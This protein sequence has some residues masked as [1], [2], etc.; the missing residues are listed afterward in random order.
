MHPRLAEKIR[1]MFL[2]G[3]YT[4]AVQQS[5]I[6]VEI[7]VREAAGMANDDLGVEMMRTVFSNKTGKLADPNATG[8]ERVAMMELFAG[9]IGHCKNPPSHRHVDTARVAAAQL[10]GLA[11]H[12]LSLVEAA[13]ARLKKSSP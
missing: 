13:E 9:A 5:F 3:D 12:L 7:T 4:I 10:I 8:G 11:S 2:R 1:P 6:E